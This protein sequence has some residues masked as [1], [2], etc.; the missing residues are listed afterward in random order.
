LK[1]ILLKKI[2]NVLKMHPIE[3]TFYKFIV[4]LTSAMA[5]GFGITN[6]VYFNKIRLNNNCQP[7]STTTANVLI[8]LNII[9]VLFG[10]ILFIWS[11]FRLI[12]TGKEEKIVV[13]KKN[14]VINYP[15]VEMENLSNRNIPNI[16]NKDPFEN[17]YNPGTE[18]EINF[19]QEYT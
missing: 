17:K 15:D 6:I 8:W 7:I 10:G 2:K 16:T 9:L 18:A 14:N 19:E 13:N 12:F 11:L 4:L 5:I 1:F 3:F